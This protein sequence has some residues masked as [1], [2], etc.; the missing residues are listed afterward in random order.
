MVI[1]A[2]RANATQIG[3]LRLRDT[4]SDF[5]SDFSL[6]SWANLSSSDEEISVKSLNCIFIEFGR[7]SEKKMSVSKGED[8]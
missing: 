6:I 2:I 7:I 3:L 8:L 4:P 1:E 5:T